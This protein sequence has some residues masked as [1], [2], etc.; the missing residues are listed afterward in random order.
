MIQY[1]EK[2]HE[3][4]GLK[5]I[6]AEL[7]ILGLQNLNRLL[8][9]TPGKVHHQNHGGQDAQQHEVVDHKASQ[10]V[11]RLHVYYSSVST[12]SRHT[13]DAAASSI[14]GLS[15]CCFH[16]RREPPSTAWPKRGI[17]FERLCPFTLRSKKAG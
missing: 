11:H 9:L 14:E 16:S 13:L 17:T 10:A 3:S 8:H 7:A 1:I 15:L 2:S 12:E 4:F 6:A 5:G